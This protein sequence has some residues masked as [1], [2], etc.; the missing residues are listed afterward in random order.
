VSENPDH[1]DAQLDEALEST[2]PASDPVS[3][4]PSPS[5]SDRRVRADRLAFY[6]VGAFLFG[7]VIGRASSSIELPS[8]PSRKRSHESFNN[9]LEAIKSL[10]SRHTTI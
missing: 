4:T 8:L 7:C 6:L 10:L 1:I 5:R 9:A 2:F 3:L